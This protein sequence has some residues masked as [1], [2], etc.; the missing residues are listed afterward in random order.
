MNITRE[1]LDRI[2]K[3]MAVLWATVLGG[4]ACISEGKAPGNVSLAIGLEE[5]FLRTRQCVLELEDVKE[6]HS[7]SLSL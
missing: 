5:Q 7:E 4:V 3:E 2:E 6:P 1:Q